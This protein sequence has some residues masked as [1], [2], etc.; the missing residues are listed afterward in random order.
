MISTTTTATITEIPKTS[1]P[2]KPSVVHDRTLPPPPPLSQTTQRTP[3]TNSCNNNN[4]EKEE[5]EEEE[6]SVDNNDNYDDNEHDANRDLEQQPPKENDD[7]EEPCSVAS[8]AREVDKGRRRSSS[9]DG[10]ELSVH[11]T[12][13][14]LPPPPPPVKQYWLF[15]RQKTESWTRNVIGGRINVFHKQRS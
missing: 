14:S 4:K 1:C 9:R 7:N 10:N 5:E 2:A 13:E 15:Q 12:H 11:L 8:C 3:T 6:Y